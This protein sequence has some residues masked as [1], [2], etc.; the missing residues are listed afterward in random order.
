MC[1]VVV[2][3]VVSVGK[4]GCAMGEGSLAWQALDSMG[5]KWE[6]FGGHREQRIRVARV[7]CGAE[8]SS[9]RSGRGAFQLWEKPL[10][11]H[12]NTRCS[13]SLWTHAGNEKPQNPVLSLELHSCRVG[14]RC[15]RQTHTGQW[16]CNPW[17]PT[18]T[19]TNLYRLPPQHCAGN[20]QGPSMVTTYITHT[21]SGVSGPHR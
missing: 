10:L 11:S 3:V 12:A 5:L 17:D 19:L 16:A 4:P 13:L 20:M 21:L 14:S 6:A 9:G 7:F 18:G 8:A 15:W 1:V 2:V